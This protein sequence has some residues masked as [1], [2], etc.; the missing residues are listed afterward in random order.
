VKIFPGIRLG[1]FSNDIPTE[2]DVMTMLVTLTLFLKSVSVKV[3][4][5]PLIV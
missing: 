4:W 1:S 2:G 3:L 5:V